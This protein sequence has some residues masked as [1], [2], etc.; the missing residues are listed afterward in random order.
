[1]VPVAGVD[2]GAA[3]DEVADAVAFVGSDARAVVVVFAVIASRT[4][5]LNRAVEFA[6]TVTF[7]DGVGSTAVVDEVTLDGSGKGFV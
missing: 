5:P 3:T 1:M 6:G 4:V 7:T 2:E